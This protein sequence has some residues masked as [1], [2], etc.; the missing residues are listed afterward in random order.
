MTPPASPPYFLDAI[1]D[2]YELPPAGT[3]DA[4]FNVLIAH[5]H[6]LDPQTADLR[7][8]STAGVKHDFHRTSKV[9]K[10]GIEPTTSSV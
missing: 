6:Q 2:E 3:P 9:G 7:A 8:E 1:D 5:V 10:V 4:D